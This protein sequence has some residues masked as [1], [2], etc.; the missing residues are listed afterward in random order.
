MEVNVAKIH[1]IIAEYVFDILILRFQLERYWSVSH[2][3]K[4]DIMDLEN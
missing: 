2:K 3:Y 4:Y 1:Q